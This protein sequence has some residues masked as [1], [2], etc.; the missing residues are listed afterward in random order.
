VSAPRLDPAGLARFADA[1]AS[2]RGRRVRWESLWS[3]FASAFP[4]RPQGRQERE[5]LAAALEHE[6]AAGR[7]EFPSERGAHWDRSL[8]PAL[9]RMVTRIEEAAPADDA[10]RRLVWHPEL[11]WVPTM[12]RLAT[13]QVAFLRRVHQGLVEGW[14]ERLAPV[15]YRSLQLTGDDKR[16]EDL[17]AGSLFREGRLSLDGIGAYRV[18]QPLVWERVGAGGRVL[19]FENQEPFFVAREILAALERP[20]YGIVAYGHGLSFERSVAHLATL[21][22]QPECIHYVGDLDGPGLEIAA[23]SARAAETLGSLPPLLAAPGMHAAM[24]SSAAIM[25]VPGGWPADNW[26]GRLG[27]EAL[28]LLPAEIRPRVRDLLESAHRVPEEVLGPEEMARVFRGGHS[29]VKPSTS[30][31]DPYGTDLPS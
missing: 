21:P 14:F 4:H 16:L 27:D 5:W 24:L 23:R 12:P 29:P 1:L 22:F 9:P 20:P 17:A 11:A 2:N 8:P 6:R 18:C 25:G 3:A 13:E 10:W 7:I 30:A 26:T 15:R 31:T 28:A 19:V